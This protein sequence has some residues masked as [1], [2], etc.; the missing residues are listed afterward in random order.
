MND[1]YT[2]FD[3]IIDKYDVYK[4]ETIGDA[5]MCGSGLP[6]RNGNLHAREVAR[7]SLD[8]RD[9][10]ACFKIPHKPDQKLRIRI[11]I[12][13]GPCVAGVVGLKMPKYCLFGE[14]V[15]LASFLESSGEP[16]KVHISQRTKDILNKHFPD[17]QIVKRGEI[18]SQSNGLIT[19]YW[20]QSESG[21]GAQ[22]NSIMTTGGK[23]E[24]LSQDDK[25]EKK[26]GGREEKKEEKKQGGRE[27]KKEEKKQG[28]REEKKEEKK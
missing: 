17:F 18:D 2:T 19:T 21:R 28:G 1:L 4:V 10:I 22:S 27:E 16:L 24:E 8:L 5:Y 9:A 13:S 23:R 15:N 12:N 3:E 26:Q 7:M 6:V 20:L 25:E 14:T 11:G